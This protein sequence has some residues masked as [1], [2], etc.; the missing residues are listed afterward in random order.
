M[1]MCGISPLIIEFFATSL[2][3]S[4]VHLFLNNSC[5]G[6][7]KIRR[8]IFQGGSV[9]LLYFVISM[10]PLSLLLNKQKIG[11]QL[12]DTNVFHISHRFYMDDL[13]LYSNTQENM[14]QLVNITSSFS[15]D[16]AMKFGLDKCTTISI[17]KRK[18]GDAKSIPL[19]SGNQI[20]SIDEEGYKY[21]GILESDNILHKEMKSKVSTEY[22][23]RVKK[24]LK[25][26]LHG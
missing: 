5:L 12:K 19:P 25:S 14:Q 24:V 6:E 8:G 13:K 3:Q 2:S 10:P 26:Q 1:A 22:Y 16:I 15:T 23:R 17:S 9:S 20:E 18:L 11:Y 4:Y 21:L 7:I